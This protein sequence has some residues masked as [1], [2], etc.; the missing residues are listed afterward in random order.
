MIRDFL[1][2]LRH[3][4]TMCVVHNLDELLTLAQTFKTEKQ[5]FSAMITVPY[6]LPALPPTPPRESLQNIPQEKCSSNPP[7][8]PV[9]YLFIY[10][11]LS[12]FL[13][14]FHPSTLVIPSIVINHPDDIL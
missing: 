9:S 13:Q 2:N 8:T 4:Q 1:I 7:L 14:H 6:L 5:F 12:T 10:Q 11:L 3:T